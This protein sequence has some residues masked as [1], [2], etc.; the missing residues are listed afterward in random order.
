MNRTSR[1]NPISPK[2]T[3]LKVLMFPSLPVSA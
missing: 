3:I 1:T 2:I